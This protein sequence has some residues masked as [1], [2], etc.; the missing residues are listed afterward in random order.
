MSPPT[1]RETLMTSLLVVTAVLAA[2]PQQYVQT[3]FGDQAIAQL[4]AAEVAQLSAADKQIAWNLVLAAHAGEEIQYDQL[5]WKNVEAKRLLERV[6]L[7][8]RAG[9]A[10]FEAQLTDYL[11][12]FYGNTG[13][14]DHNTGVKF[15]PT[16]SFEALRAAAQR[17]LAAGA[18]FP[19]RDAAALD[20]HLAWLRPTLFDAAFEP[21]STSKSPP[22]GQD[23]VTASSNTAYGP[24]VTLADL[25]KFEEKNA[26]NSRVLK[27]GGKLRE[28][29]FRSGT[30]DGSVPAGRYADA[31]ARVNA[32]LKAAAA[33]AQPDQREALQRLIRYFQS[34]DLAD[35][36]AY[37]IA[38]L[39]ADP[40]V[41][42]NLGFIETY[43]D[44]RGQK[45]QWEAL[46]N[47]KA[48]AEQKVM[49]LLAENTLY[50]EQKMPW[51][52]QYKR[53]EIAPPV[54]KAINFIAAYPQPPAGINLPNEQHIRQKYG[55][56][57][58]LV[59]NTM[60]TAAAVRRIPLS[61]E[62]SVDAAQRKTSEQY[63]VEAR[64][65]LVAFH[66]VT[67]HASGQVDKNL[68]G[69]PSSHLKEYDNTLEEAR[70]DL[71]ALW[72]AFDPKLKALNPEYE[73]IA[74]QMYR[75]FLVDCLVIHSRTHGDT[76]EEDHQRGEHLT[77]NFLIEKVAVKVRKIKQPAGSAVKVKTYYVVEDFPKVRAAVGE[78][79]SK[80]MVI[81]A[82][83]DYQGIKTLVNRLGVKLDPALRD[84]VVARVKAANVPTVVYFSSPRI[85][86]VVDAQGK[87]SD[88]AVSHDQDFILQHLERSVLGRLSPE[89]A[90][91]F[92][93]QP[94]T[95]DS[96]RAGFKA[97]T[98][99]M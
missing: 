98:A 85:A 10:G 46:I 61:L 65:L 23:L 33:V 77:A 26:L 58:V 66:E 44:A 78:L 63:A 2:T 5:G 35:W 56:K 80:L 76:F 28:V 1:F 24:G 20:A 62:F 67:G 25:E 42:V 36:D 70:A 4:F 82:T 72:H 75:D 6:Y 7:F 30:P 22:P 39:K 64:K 91:K 17:A 31:L 16:F 81:K 50:F 41:D 87:V 48:P 53:T 11:R 14:H 73:E 8:G 74:K 57:S 27:E 18:P 95:E 83:G 99:G 47:F 71:V 79:L 54:A 94:V 68:K 84:E 59:A 13:N 29:V 43:V 52:E 40:T 89:E 12:R 97:I 90:V 55:S 93:E 92:A 38:W 60:E 9:D 21:Q 86:P 45:G 96:L 32:H 51:P 88:L 19:Q 15:V 3:R 49:D 69:N 37:N 34:G